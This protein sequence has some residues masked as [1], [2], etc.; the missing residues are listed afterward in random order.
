VAQACTNVKLA[1]VPP[2]GKIEPP[3]VPAS[4]GTGQFGGNAGQRVVGMQDL[5]ALAKGKQWRELVYRASDVPPSKRAKRWDELVTTASINYIAQLVKKDETDEAMSFARAAIETF[6][7]LRKSKEFI[8]QSSKVAL[9]GAQHCFEQACRRYGGCQSWS[10]YGPDRCA[11]AL[12]E[13]VEADPTNAELAKGAGL[14][15]YTH[16]TEKWRAAPYFW[17]S[18]VGRSDSP[19]CAIEEVQN[20]MLWALRTK[21]DGHPATVA[22]EVAARWCWTAFSKSLPDQVTEPDPYGILESG[23][24]VLKERKA[25]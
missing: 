23:C 19:D 10:E 11:K 9:A 8:S 25:Y 15:V 2:A 20:S 5:E 14:L 12:L 6:P 1:S 21:E 22:R 18:L 4:S 16:A 7:I 3:E 17:Y 24:A 13:A